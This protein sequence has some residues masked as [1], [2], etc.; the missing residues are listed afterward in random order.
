MRRGKGADVK[1]N[2]TNFHFPPIETDVI[3]SHSRR[4]W[5]WYCREPSLLLTMIQNF[6]S[7][8]YEMYQILE[9]FRVVAAAAATV[10]GVVGI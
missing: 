6:M 10:A 9:L 7:V 8:P 4:W 1:G 3:I 5:W 2:T